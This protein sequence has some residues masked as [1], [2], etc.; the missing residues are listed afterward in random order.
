MSPQPQPHHLPSSPREIIHLYTQPPDKHSSMAHRKV[1]RWDLSDDTLC[2]TETIAVSVVTATLLQT[3]L[4]VNQN[5]PETCKVTISTKRYHKCAVIQNILIVLFDCM[6]LYI[7]AKM[8]CKNSDMQINTPYFTAVLRHV[9][10]C[11]VFVILISSYIFQKSKELCGTK[12]Y[13][14]SILFKL[15]TQLSTERAE[16]HNEALLTKIP[17]SLF[18]HLLRQYVVTWGHNLTIFIAHSWQH[19]YI[20][21]TDINDVI[22]V[23]N[24]S[25]NT[26]VGNIHIYIVYIL[27]LGFKIFSVKWKK[28]NGV[29]WSLNP[30]NMYW[31]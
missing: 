6:C 31:A 3:V 13:T 14:L 25:S 10:L 1:L 17:L 24:L 5:Y 15:Y 11:F 30:E 21:M 23:Q 18:K 26:F 16:C 4:S 8:D 22:N 12:Y 2:K 28:W 27:S 29:C 7:F 9:Q 20:L 19:V